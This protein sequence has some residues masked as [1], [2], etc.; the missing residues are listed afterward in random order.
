M[1]FS[2]QYRY[3]PLWL[4][5]YFYPKFTYLWYGDLLF[6]ASLNLL[7]RYLR[8]RNG[9]DLNR[10]FPDPILQGGSV[11]DLQA[12]G[13]EE[14]ETLN[15]M[16]WI[17]STHFVASASLHEVSF[18]DSF[19]CTYLSHFHANFLEAT[20]LVFIIRNNDCLKT[21]GS[22]S[23]RNPLVNCK[24]IHTHLSGTQVMTHSS[25]TQVMGQISAKFRTQRLAYKQMS[26]SFQQVHL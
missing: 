2:K 9:I 11:S 22:I 14:P 8:C 25:G 6:T 4:Q 18:G 10:N 26:T 20:S 12:T 7:K 1:P 17:Q 5:G 24:G 23:G 15:V 19:Y 16:K 13:I 21:V 3:T